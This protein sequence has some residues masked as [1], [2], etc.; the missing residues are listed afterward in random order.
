MNGI[1]VGAVSR[2]VT[3]WNLYDVQDFLYEN[4]QR[5]TADTWQQVADDML[6]VGVEIQRIAETM[7]DDKIQEKDRELQ[8]LQNELDDT[9]IDKDRLESDLNDADRENEQLESDLEERDSIISSLRDRIDELEAE[10]ESL[11][12]E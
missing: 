3:Q 9:A 2:P 6:L 4:G 7:I 1:G 5:M 12:G 8:E 10:L 11:Q